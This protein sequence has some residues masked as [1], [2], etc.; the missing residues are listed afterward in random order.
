MLDRI[1]DRDLEVLYKAAAGCAMPSVYEGFGLPI[2]E[3]M[4]SGVPVMSSNR[5][6]LP[7]VGGNAV[8]Y[9]DP[10]SVEDMSFAMERLLGDSELRKKLVERG[11]QRAKQFSWEA[12]ARTTLD[13]LRSL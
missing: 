6:S 12:C 1:P 10:E 3:A 7:E 13:A 5:S 11:L 4:A 8:L 9:F 2:L